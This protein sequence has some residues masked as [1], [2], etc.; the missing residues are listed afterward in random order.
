M[1]ELP[2]DTMPVGKVKE[3]C[4]LT[5][6]KRQL[7]SEVKDLSR[8]I[9]AREEEL[10][11]HFSKGEVPKVTVK[12]ASGEQRTVYLRR[13]LWASCSGDTN[14]LLEYLRSHGMEDFTTYS[15]QR[16]SAY[17]REHDAEDKELPQELADLIKVSEVFKLV[18]TK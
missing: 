10:L 12:V 7:E 11:S 16:L 15:P 13:Q 6:R 14:A 3:L 8:Q 9:A 1:D 5:E 2:V 4:D 17:V 18:V